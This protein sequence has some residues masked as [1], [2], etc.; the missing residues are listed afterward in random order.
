MRLILTRPLY[1]PVLNK[2]KLTQQYGFNLLGQTI[3]SI[4]ITVAQKSANDS[5]FLSRELDFQSVAVRTV[6]LM[7]GLVVISDIATISAIATLPQKERCPS[8]LAVM[9]LNIGIRSL[10]SKTTR[11][12]QIKEFRRMNFFIEVI[13]K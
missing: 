1:G 9:R 8:I 7:L 5:S 10:P 12:T 3:R 4:A 6:R 13:P 2:V 11:C